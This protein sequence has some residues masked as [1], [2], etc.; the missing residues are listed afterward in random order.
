MGLRCSLLLPLEGLTRS[1]VSLLNDGLLQAESTL[2]WLCRLVKHSHELLNTLRF[3]AVKLLLLLLAFLDLLNFDLAE[4]DH[5]ELILLLL[6]LVDDRLQICLAHLPVTVLLVHFVLSLKVRDLFLLL[7]N[8]LD[9]VVALL[10]QI[11]VYDVYGAW[12]HLFLLFVACVGELVDDLL[13]SILKLLVVLQL[14]GQVVDH[15]LL[16]IFRHH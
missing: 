16:H 13:V 2:L 6:S 10:E 9:L 12:L 3:V 15:L 8:D 14:S 1:Y 11:L 4:F 7:V 5:L